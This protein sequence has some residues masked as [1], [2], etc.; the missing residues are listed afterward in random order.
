MLKKQKISNNPLTYQLFE[1]LHTL[2]PIYLGFVREIRPELWRWE[3]AFGGNCGE[4]DIT[5]ALNMV[6]HCARSSDTAKKF[7]R[8]GIQGV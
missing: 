3:S 2:D 5:H 1:K 4:G 6:T 7:K 8:K